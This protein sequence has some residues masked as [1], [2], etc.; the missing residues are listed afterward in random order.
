MTAVLVM[1][2]GW[3]LGCGAV[4]ALSR[5]TGLPARKGGA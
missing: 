2:A 5:A 4:V 1:L 3:L